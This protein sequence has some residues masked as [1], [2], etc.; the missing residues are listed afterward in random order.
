MA[1]LFTMIQKS[2]ITLSSDVPS[3]TG[4]RLLRAFTCTPTNREASRL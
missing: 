1:T 4:L 3:G 2:P